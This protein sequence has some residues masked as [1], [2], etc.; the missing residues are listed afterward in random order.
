MVDI[1]TECEQHFW[2]LINAA[3]REPFCSTP[4]PFCLYSWSQ[5]A[6]NA[7]TFR[8]LTKK[9]NTFQSKFSFPMKCLYMPSLVKRL[10]EEFDFIDVQSEFELSM[11]DSE[12]RVSFHSPLLPESIFNEPRVAQVSLNSLAQV[13]NL[14]LLAPK[15]VGR[16]GLR[17]SF[18]EGWDSPGDGKTGKFGLRDDEVDEA[19]KQLKHY[20]PSPAIFFHHHSH[21]RLS[22]EQLA[23]QMVVK[24]LRFM[25][26]CVQRTGIEVRKINLGGGWDGGLEFRLK[27][28]TV[29]E[30]LSVQ[31][32][33]VQR[34]APYVNEVILEPGRYIVED[35]AIAVATVQEVIDRGTTQ[36]AIIDIATGFLVPLDLARFRFVVLNPT[37]Q[38]DPHA[39]WL[40]DGTCSPKGAIANQTISKRIRAGTRIA[41]VNCGAYTYS[42]AGSF[43][44]PPPPAYLVDEKCG[45]VRLV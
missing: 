16:I 2:H 21:A 14:Q 39:V 42:V 1:E 34:Y 22:D 27:G 12:S 24:F 36:Y 9:F 38:A 37:A 19:L 10:S 13:K 44:S 40:V 30:V 15:H 20:K 23:E 45:S 28:K 4:T 29:N 26:T 25:E 7:S 18:P 6:K 17:V 5:L 31:L 35:S 43:H 33:A 32:D 11:C 3:G 8:S 41:V